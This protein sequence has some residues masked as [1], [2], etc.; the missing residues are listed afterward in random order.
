[1]KSIRKEVVVQG[2][3]S[4]HSYGRESP[5]H[6]GTDVLTIVL[7][8]RNTARTPLRAVWGYY[9]SMVSDKVRL[10]FLFNC[11]LGSSVCIG[12]SLVY[13]EL[14]LGTLLSIVE[15]KYRQQHFTRL[16]VSTWPHRQS[17]RIY[18][19]DLLCCTRN[20]TQA[21]PVGQSYKRQGDSP[22]VFTRTTLRV[23]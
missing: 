15:K 10:H 14:T 17:V 9:G 7:Q 2:S 11:L 6:L 20:Q 22:L 3:L 21:R 4:R 19:K 8:V 16:H 23:Q 13:T 18:A 12:K 5:C 1:M